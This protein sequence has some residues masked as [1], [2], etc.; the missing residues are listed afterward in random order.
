MTE[1]SRHEWKSGPGYASRG[2]S[3]KEVRKIEETIRRDVRTFL[4][5]PLI[6]KTRVSRVYP[7][8]V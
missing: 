8:F 4:V 7:C 2:A 3:E 1:R 5:C 6:A